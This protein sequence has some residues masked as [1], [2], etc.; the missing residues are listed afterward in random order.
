MKILRTVGALRQTLDARQ[1]G[2]TVGF[3]PTMG[4]LHDGHLA[5]V[6]AARAASGLVVVSIFVNPKQF[7]DASDLARYPRQ[8][9]RDTELADEAG[10]DVLF[11]PDAD[12]V[13]ADGHATSI[14]VQGPALGFEGD[15]RPGHFDGVA[16][17]CL[18]LFAMVE[19]DLVFLGQKDAQQVAVL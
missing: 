18:K 1:S 12:E 3:V 7:T 2:A 6:R 19:P 14:H 17:V 15:H 16:I 11:V 4:A 8:E 10:A 13:Y 5:L 9:S